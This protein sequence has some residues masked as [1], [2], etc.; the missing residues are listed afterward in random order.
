V[1]GTRTYTYTTEQWVSSSIP[2]S[3]MIKMH[4]SY[5]DNILLRFPQFYFLCT[6]Y[7]IVYVCHE[8]EIA[9]FLRLRC[10]FVL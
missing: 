10:I 8:Y 1:W 6:Y 5:W 7:L 9:S 3:E 2:L 4:S